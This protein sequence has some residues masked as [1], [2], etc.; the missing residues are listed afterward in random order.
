MTPSISKSAGHPIT[1][2]SSRILKKNHSSVKIL[3]CGVKTWACMAQSGNNILFCI[4]IR[5]SSYYCLSD[6]EEWSSNMSLSSKLD[7]ITF[8][9]PGT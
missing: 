1:S 6:S 4:K 3:A 9:S 7:I 2:R 5:I 8:L